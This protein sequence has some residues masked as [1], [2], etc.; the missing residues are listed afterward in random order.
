MDKKGEMKYH[1]I[2]KLVGAI[3][4]ALGFLVMVFDQTRLG[5]I[6][7]GIGTIVIALGE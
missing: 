6:L 5:T 1:F 4:G 3:I 2:I 7:V